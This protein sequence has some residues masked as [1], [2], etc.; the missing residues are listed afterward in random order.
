MGLVTTGNTSNKYLF[1]MQSTARLPEIARI[2]L[3]LIKEN[4]GKTAQSI[5]MNLNENTKIIATLN[6]QTNTMKIY[7]EK[8]LETYINTL[9]F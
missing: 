3:N 2:S 9:V 8:I 7:S 4:I 5:L 1:N 6:N